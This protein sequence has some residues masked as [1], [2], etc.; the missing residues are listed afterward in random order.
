LRRGEGYL[1]GAY[2]R[3]GAQHEVPLTHVLAGTAQVVPRA[4]RLSKFELL[5]PAG[6][7]LDHH[8]R[9]GAFGYH[10]TGED[11]Y[12]LP[13]PHL[14]LGRSPRRSLVDDLEGPSGLDV[15]APHSI[16]IHRRVVERRRVEPRPHVLGEREPLSIYERRARDWQTGGVLQ[17]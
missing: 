1:R 9:V 2:L 4:G 3:A 10:A 8:D 17:H 13:L 14:L 7:V 16:S 5:A 11:L 15:R 12:G 6:G